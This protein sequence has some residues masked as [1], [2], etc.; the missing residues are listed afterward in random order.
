MDLSSVL[1]KLSPA[2]RARVDVLQASLRQVWYPDH[3][4]EPQQ[5]AYVSKA[6]VIGFGG[7]AGGGKTDLALGL[8]LT[9][10]QVVQF[11][12]REGTE[13]QA[14][15]D[16]CA[17]IVGTR[18]GLGGRP[19]IWRDPTKR[20]RLIEFCSVPHLGDEVAYQGRAKDLLVIDEASNFL[21]SQV[22]FLMGWVRSTDAA[23]HC[24][25]LMTFNPPTSTEGRWVVS[26]FAPWLDKRYGGKRA[27]PGELR[28]FAR[29]DGKDRE[30]ESAAPFEHAGEIVTPMSRTF[31]PSR[32]ANNRFLRDTAYRATL[33]ALP[34][35]LR[36]QMLHGDFDA[37]MQDDPYQVIPTKWV[38]AAMVRWERKHVVPEMDAMGVDVALGG[39]DNTVIARRHGMWFDVPIVYR[40][41]DCPDGPTIAGYIVAA[42]RDRAPIHI[43][44]FG[45]GAQPYGHLMAAHVQ[46]LGVNVG[47]PSG[48]TTKNGGIRF[49]NK[50]S[51]LWWKMRE[52]L[53]PSA[54]NGIALPQDSRLLAD[55]CAPLWELKGGIVQ[56]ESREKIVDRL[57]RS[58]DFASAYCLALMGTIK[59]HV[60]RDLVGR[61][62]PDYTLG[63][64]PLAGI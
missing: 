35:P 34:E 44:L 38:E 10:H 36:S 20:C 8:S 1:A 49:R 55:L 26:Y 25:T 58:P 30:V 52:A 42:Q 11:F 27:Q 54:N 9:R 48:A 40:G 13:L 56:V 12:R 14:I 22:L 17:E 4:N 63:H 7:A 51:E 59:T 24:Q 3:E 28:W 15:I 53:D 29:V 37:G 39:D 2:E 6:D 41:R 64:D 43:D 33:Q 23:Q 60:A 16:R 19:P 18:E 61:G 5:L 31:I 50:R 47:D 62:N 46:V 57:G 45:V 32:L 21:E